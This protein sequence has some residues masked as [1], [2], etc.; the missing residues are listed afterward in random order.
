MTQFD[1]WD[2]CLGI[3][4]ENSISQSNLEHD[5]TLITKINA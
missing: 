4:G 1:I 5:I 3:W 2:A